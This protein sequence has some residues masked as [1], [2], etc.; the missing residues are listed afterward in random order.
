MVLHGYGYQYSAAL[1]HLELV[2][3]DS[4]RSNFVF[5]YHIL[6]ILLHSFFSLHFFTSIII[7]TIIIFFEKN[8]NQ[9][10]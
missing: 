6:E 5:Q 2:A 10:D 7:I 1:A 9:L 4:V 3:E 8:N